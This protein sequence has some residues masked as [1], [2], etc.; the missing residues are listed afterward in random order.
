MMSKK[1]NKMNNQ[2]TDTQLVKDYIEG[3]ENAISILIKKRRNKI[4]GFIYSKTLNKEVSN[5]I[6]Q[7]TFLK[8]IINLKSN[9]YNEQNKFMSWV[10]RIAH[11]LIMD[12]FRDTGKMPMY[13]EKEGFPLFS[14]MDDG[15]LTIE[16]SIISENIVEDLK[17]LIEKLPPDQKEVVVMRMYLKMSYKEIAE[18]TGVGINTALGKM[19]YATINLRNAIAKHQILLTHY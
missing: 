12:H 19:R 13:R 11:N 3:D 15:A 7:D 1:Y 18:E 6:F 17:K 2:R 16:N 5:D 10:L 9:S 8:V 4:Y 14:R